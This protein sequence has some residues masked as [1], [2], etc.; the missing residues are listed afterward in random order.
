MPAPA[1]PRTLDAALVAAFRN[2]TRADL[3]AERERLLIELD[4]ENAPADLIDRAEAVT[5][6]LE[7]RAAAD[8]RRARIRQNGTVARRD[9]PAELHAGREILASAGWRA[10]VANGYTG[11]MAVEIADARALI[12]TGTP[13]GLTGVERITTVYGPTVGI[14]RL[15]DVIGATL[16]SLGTVEW[17][18]ETVASAADP[19]A[20]AVE[21]AEGAAK[22]EAAVT[23][24]IGSAKIE[25][26]AA[27]V[28]LTRQLSEDDPQLE[29]YLN[30]RLTSGVRARL[31]SQIIAGNGTSPNLRGLLNTTG[32]QSV[33]GGAAEPMYSV[34]RK[35]VTK[36]QLAGFNPS[37]YVV[38]PADA[39]AADLALDLENRPLDTGPLNLPPRIVDPACPAKTTLVG[40]FTDP[41]AMQLR[42]RKEATV[43]LSD[44]HSDNF[45]KNILILLAEMRAA[46]ATYQP[47]AVC[48]GTV[49]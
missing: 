2:M 28:Q 31:S 36:V 38:S 6:E 39:E 30:A 14:P 26:I 22:P 7:A 43:L 16:T 44:S 15:V 3:T 4:D 9:G 32:V 46:L 48:K 41:G 20:G 37:H 19:T 34:V 8:E 35:C 47:Q 40:A 13:A 33:T 24:E 42:V 11:R 29:G 23:F 1:P 12:T 18:R 10:F 25:T 5:A 49:V 21:V 27:W 17:P 45:T